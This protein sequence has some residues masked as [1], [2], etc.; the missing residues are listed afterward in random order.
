MST[1]SRVLP[2]SFLWCWAVVSSGFIMYVWF[3]PNSINSLRS[4]L[5][6]LL[7]FPFHPP[8]S[9]AIPLSLPIIYL[10][11]LSMHLFN[12]CLS[13]HLNVNSMRAWSLPPP[14]KWV[15][16]CGSNLKESFEQVWSILNMS[17]SLVIFTGLYQH[18]HSL[19]FSFGLSLLVP[20][21]FLCLDSPREHLPNLMDKE[22][23]FG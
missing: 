11:L 15:L 10:F 14:N 7:C 20:D 21:L 5:M 23:E 13:P 16:T 6:P 19:L 8:T 1:M 9:S 22:T 18:D 17:G 2:Y 3:L 4:R 12:N